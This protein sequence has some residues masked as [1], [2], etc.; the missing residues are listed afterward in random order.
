MGGEK[1]GKDKAAEKSRRSTEADTQKLAQRAAARE[2]EKVS[3]RK[4]CA[5]ITII[6]C[7]CGVGFVSFVSTVL[8]FLAGTGI[9][10]IDVQDSVKLKSVLFGGDPWLIYCVTKE[11]ENLRLPSVLEASSRSLY[12]NIGVQ[13]GVLRCWDEMATGRSV[14]KRFKLRDSPPLAFLVANGNQPRVVNFVGVSKLEDLER[15]IQPALKL[16]VVTVN[17]L[18]TWSNI[19]TS[20]RACVVVGY[21]YSAQR[22]T[23]LKALRPLH[24]KHRALKMVT[25]D[26]SFWQLKLEETVLTT[27]PTDKAADVLCLA[28]EDAG[29]GNATFSGLFLQDLDSAAAFLKACDQHEGLRPLAAGAP[30]ISARPTKPKVVTPEPYKEKGKDEAKPAAKPRESKRSNVDHV[31]SR[32][33]LEREEEALFESVDE[34]EQAS[35]SDQED[36]EE[37]FE[38]VEL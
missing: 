11:T 18:K 16:E 12:S 21:K 24:E 26:T 6:S 34:S 38:D 5:G 4:R 10:V 15:K 2:V 32:D 8:K 1:N 23:A 35:S 20:R 14:A 27:R 28:R 13:V 29:G 17:S 37:S 22:D 19:C 25:L 36:D 9:T 30:R 33:Q 31:G 7:M 3:W